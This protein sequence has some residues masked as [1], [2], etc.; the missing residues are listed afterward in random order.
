MLFCSPFGYVDVCSY[1]A[2][3]VWAQRLAAT[4]VPALRFDPP[5]AGD[6]AG[7][8]LGVDLMEH[9]SEAVAQTAA[10][11]R[12]E[13]ATS[14]IVAVGIG[15]GGLVAVRAVAQGATVDDL[16]LWNTPARGRA[17]LRELRA[18]AAMEAYERKAADFPPATPL[19]EGWYGGGGFFLRSEV[20]HALE[21]LDLASLWLPAAGG[22]RA[23]LLDR[24]GIAVDP[25][26]HAHLSAQGIDVQVGLG[27]GYGEMTG[28]PHDSAAPEQVFDV[29][30]RWLAEAPVEPVSAATPRAPRAA[31]ELLLGNVRER[32]FLVDTSY[33]RLVGVLAQRAEGTHEPLTLVLLNVGSI[34]RIGPGRMWVE[35]ARRWAE[36]GV[37][38]L[39][40]DVEG[41]G[42]SDGP[43]T[44]YGDLTGLYQPRIVT[45]VRAALDALE[46]DGVPGPFV[47]GGICSAAFWSFHCA[48]QDA[49]VRAVILINPA[50]LFWDPA[51]PAVREARKVQKLARTSQLRRLL[52]GDV[53]LVNIL[54]VVRAMAAV[55]GRRARAPWRRLTG[56][57]APVAAVETAFN[58]LR[59]KDCRVTLAFSAG[60]E[61]LYLKLDRDGVLNGLGNWPNMR[62]E[63]I[64]GHD[65]ILRPPDMQ[66]NAHR[67]IDSVIVDELRALRR[68]PRR[69]GFDIVEV[70]EIEEALRQEPERYLQRVYTDREVEACRRGG[71]VNGRRLAQRFAAKEAVMKLLGAAPDD[72]LPWRAIEILEEA[73]GCARVELHGEAIV[74]AARA[75]I[76]DLSVS[77]THAAGCAAAVVIGAAP[78]RGNS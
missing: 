3:R 55:A 54:S 67:I 75:G 38:V 52:T 64:P 34:R 74:L 4:G 29:V 46:R 32:E 10:W 16:V 78:T 59:D 7:T 61:D 42:D 15:L 17:F 51:L 39:R 23:L 65:H 69:I 25:R 50:V 18:V 53:A 21:E 1:R 49:R 28:R 56:L 44:P 20:C 36:R 68:A 41:I 71:V 11:L 43:A 40:L 57:D 35:A 33:G 8:S 22:R 27:S 72:P 31:T 58:S 66:D 2:R 26:L 77:L 62:L 5:G 9:W 45:Q 19:P 13:T 76:A 12:A 60:G 73:P 47:L 14:R 48:L 24:D 30:D 70:E 63:L 37:A 6:S